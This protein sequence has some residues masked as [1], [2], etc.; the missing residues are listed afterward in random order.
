ML[1][2][3]VPALEMFNDETQEFITTKEQTLCL[4]H[5]LLSIS[6]WESKWHKPYLTK[7]KKTTEETI[8]YIRCM[9]LTQNVSPEVYLA[10]TERNFE[11]IA[12]YIDN[13]MTATW[14]S[15]N[16]TDK[17]N[18]Q[19]VT[20]E[21]VY[22]WMFSLQIPKEC[23]KWHIARLMTL[24]RI[25]NA[26]NQDSKNKGQVTNDMM[27]QRRALNEARKKQLNTKG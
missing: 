11:E 12:D 20:S 21:L 14:F 19:Q 26:E 8:D 3:T 17:T 16:S 1:Q 23:E 4:E 25:F 7:V 15:G 5:S 13:P 6:K 24:I 2:I 27:A 10:L 18:R 22:Y 9:T